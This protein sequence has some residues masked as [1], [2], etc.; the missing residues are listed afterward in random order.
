MLNVVQN[1]VEIYRLA[2]TLVFDRLPCCNFL[3]LAFFY[4]FCFSTL[5][6]HFFSPFNML[7]PRAL[8]IRT[9]KDIELSFCCKV[10]TGVLLYKAGDFVDVG[11]WTHT[12]IHCWHAKMDRTYCIV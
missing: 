2:H 5:P 7:V 10:E 6:Y 12:H 9:E 8:I 3:H 4:R 11:I 1:N